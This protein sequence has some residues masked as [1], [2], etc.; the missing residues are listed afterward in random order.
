MPPL[1]LTLLVIVTVQL[2]ARFSLITTEQV[3][4]QSFASVTVTLCV[5]ALSA[6]ARSVVSPLSHRYSN[7]DEPPI[8]TTEALPSEKPLQLASETSM[9]EQDIASGSTKVTEQTL[10]HIGFPCSLTVT[11]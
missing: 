4:V 2:T 9:V 11:I 3:M 10:L 7:G 5:P 1:Q 8:G 6:M